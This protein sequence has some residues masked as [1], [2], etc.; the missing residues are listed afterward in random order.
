MG[1]YFL[2]EG[3]KGSGLLIRG[4]GLLVRGQKGR[5][6]KEREGGENSP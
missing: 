3:G 2:R 5:E 1:A 4:E 6:E